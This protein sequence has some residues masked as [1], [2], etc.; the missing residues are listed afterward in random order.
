MKPEG[1]LERTKDITTKDAQQKELKPP[2]SKNE[3]KSSVKTKKIK[4]SSTDKHIPIIGT[5]TSILVSGE[6]PTTSK[7]SKDSGSR[8]TRTRTN[9]AL[10]AIL[11]RNSDQT[12]T[13]Q[14]SF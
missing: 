11:K 3:D 9:V 10:Q 14:V 13:K 2:P 1:S 4:I 12:E 8:T 7:V 5:K 6:T